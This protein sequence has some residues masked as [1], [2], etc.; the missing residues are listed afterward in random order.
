[1]IVDGGNEFFSLATNPA[2]LV[3][4]SCGVVPRAVEIQRRL[5]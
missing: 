1:V 5:G 3:C 2:S 4:T